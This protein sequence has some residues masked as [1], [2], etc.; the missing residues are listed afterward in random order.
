MSAEAVEEKTDNA[1]EVAT[2]K[3]PGLKS[4]LR[5]VLM[6]AAALLV[7]LVLV[8][9]LKKA[10]ESTSAKR[11]GSRTAVVRRTSFV[12]SVRLHGV[13][14]A[15]QYYG[16]T[17]PRMSGPGMSSLIVTK[18]AKSGTKVKT[19]DLLVEFD[20]QQQIRNALDR[21][22]EYRDLLQQI[23]KK[24]ADQA[25][26]LAT[27]QTE[28]AKAEH[29][30]QA[31]SLELRKNEVVSQI[32]AEKNRQNLE[33]AKAAFDQLKQTFQLKRRAAV[34]ELRILEIQRD[35]AFNAMRYSQANA[36]RMSVRSPIDGVVVLNM[37]WKGGQMGEVK[38]G[39][40]I[41]PGTP[42]M[43]V[44][45]PVTMQ[46]RALAN[47]ADVLKLQQG[48]RARVGLDAY[49]ELSL[50]GTVANI[51]AEG[52]PSISDAVRKFTVLVPISG[53]DP[54]LMPDLSAAVDVELSRQDSVLIVPRDA[55][56]QNAGKFS[57]VVRNGNRSTTQSVTVGEM[58]DTEAV[59]QSGLSEGNILVRNPEAAEAR[60]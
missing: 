4:T 36:N 30:V 19:G 44:V 59:V 43:Q 42:F 24:R 1:S 52:D 26:S 6:A 37:V 2:A 23:N 7:V 5:L 28:L 38:E 29:A 58:N 34:A 13:L 10:R 40:E 45:N 27:D 32:D 50:S 25:A 3:A 47:Q 56:F 49:P 60:P 21:E 57:V 53:A 8:A 55:L 54:R 9:A 33:E 39:D 14:E 35:R 12:R 11:S 16:V 18:L 31:A 15:V 22:A 20:R 41:R 17:A 48:Q 46:V 51:S